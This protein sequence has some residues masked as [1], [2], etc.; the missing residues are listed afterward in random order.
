MKLSEPSKTSTKDVVS[1][2]MYCNSTSQSAAP[3]YY[4]PRLDY[5]WIIPSYLDDPN[6]SRT[7]IDD[8][9]IFIPHINCLAVTSLHVYCQAKEGSQTSYRS[10]PM[11]LSSFCMFGIST[12][13]LTHAVTDASAADDFKKQG[14]KKR[15]CLK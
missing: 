10:A 2:H 9:S 8:N 13:P 3:L 11:D 6:F 1:G 7:T 4:K 15:N 14:D 5:K 12:L